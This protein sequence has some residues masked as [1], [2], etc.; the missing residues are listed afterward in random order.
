MG[1]QTKKDQLLKARELLCAARLAELGAR[2]GV[3][4][5][6]ADNL[7]Q[8]TVRAT[9]RQVTGEMPASGMLPHSAEWFRAC[10]DR[11]IQGML[12]INIYE[13]V[14]SDDSELIPIEQ[15]E[16]AF[17]IYSTVV[18]NPLLSINYAD[19]II[20]LVHKTQA[21][22]VRI[23]KRCAN[24]YLEIANE[25]TTICQAC[26]WHEEFFC[27][28]SGCN[29][30]LPKYAL[31]TRRGKKRAYCDACNTEKARQRQRKYTTEIPTYHCGAI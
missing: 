14:L 11:L 17:V 12:F 7:N 24:S 5:Y 19:H 31:A 28:T 13:L 1:R 6:W 26:Q 22:G 20:R 23:C 25:N 10:K 18:K 27:R 9:I 16:K 30:P 15:F 3:I 4:F 29:N 2:T 8:D 21:I